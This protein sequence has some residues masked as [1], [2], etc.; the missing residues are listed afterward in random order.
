MSNIRN[1]NG[2]AI[3]D[4][5]GCNLNEMGV[6]QVIMKLETFCVFVMFNVIGY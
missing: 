3:S 4:H 2:T 1:E 5:I 6:D